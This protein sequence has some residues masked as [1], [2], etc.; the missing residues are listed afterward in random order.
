MARCTSGRH[1]WLAI[2]DAAKCCNG[3]RRELVIGDVSG[4]STIGS[5]PL[6]GGV[7]YGYRWVPD[8]QAT[9]HPTHPNPSPQSADRT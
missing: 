6:P 5:E 1:E 3:Y 4:C 2:E 7:R 9:P 8:T